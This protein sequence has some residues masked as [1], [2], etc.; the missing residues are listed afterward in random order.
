[1]ASKKGSENGLLRNLSKSTPDN[2]TC[3]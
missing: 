1:M 2:I 3:V